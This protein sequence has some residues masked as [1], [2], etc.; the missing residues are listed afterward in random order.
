MYRLCVHTHTHTYEPPEIEPIAFIITVLYVSHPSFKK[1]NKMKQ[2]IIK[3]SIQKTLQLQPAA[4]TCKHRQ[5]LMPLSFH[6]LASSLCPCCFSFLF[7][8]I[9]SFCW[10]SRVSISYTQWALGL[11]LLPLSHCCLL[12]LIA[13]HDFW[14]SNQFPCSLFFQVPLW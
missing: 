10:L 2:F 1:W 14:S 7:E 13:L 3:K 8:L 11:W 4:Q 5:K 12:G 6:T 9:K